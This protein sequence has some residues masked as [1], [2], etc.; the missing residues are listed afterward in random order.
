MVDA[1]LTS[2]LMSGGHQSG[3]R[4]VSEALLRDIAEFCR[5]ARMAES[6]FGRLAVNDGKLVS[7]LR[8][9]GRV[10]TD[11]VDRVHGF[12]ARAPRGT[13][14]GAPLPLPLTPESAPAT[15]HNFRFY[16]NRQKYLLFVTTCGEKWVV[17]QRV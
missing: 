16:D 9:G 15:T 2:T 5:R 1:W 7:R 4:P 8:L 17:A 3:D 13:V 10:T 12:I 6:T 14:N 11:T